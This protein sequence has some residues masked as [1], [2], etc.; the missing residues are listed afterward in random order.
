MNIIGLL[1]RNTIVTAVVFYAVLA[2]GAWIANG[3]FGTHLV[4]K[5]LNDIAVFVF[6][7]LSV[8]HGINSVFNSNKGEMP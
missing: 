1:Q 8:L 5:D 3:V 7:Q 2:L 6:G 4:I